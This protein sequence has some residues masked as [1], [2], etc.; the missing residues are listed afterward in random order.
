M[1]ISH[2]PML[3]R[4]SQKAIERRQM[5]RGKKSQAKRNAIVERRAEEKTVSQETALNRC[6]DWKIFIIKVI[7][8]K[9]VIVDLRQC[10]L[11]IGF[12]GY[13]SARR[14]ETSSTTSHRLVEK[15][16]SRVEHAHEIGGRAAQRFAMKT[17]ISQFKNSKDT[18]RLLPPDR[19]RRQMSQHPFV[20][21]DNCARNRAGA[22]LV[23]WYFSWLRSSLDLHKNRIN[24]G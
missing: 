20:S 14:E 11:T 1:Q 18:P 9:C 15:K 5:R 24:C 10:A 2:S 16:A 17:R 6:Q 13:T 3:K 22:R 23:V 21:R 4:N 19:I 8:S 12:I 7:I